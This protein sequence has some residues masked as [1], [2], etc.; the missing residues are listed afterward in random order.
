MK[1]SSHQTIPQWKAI[2]QTEWDDWRWQLRNACHS[3]G[4]VN[5]ALASFTDHR[6]NLDPKQEA[7]IANHLAVKITPQMVLALKRG[8]AGNVRNSWEAFR[9]AFL[10]AVEE[11]DFPVDET[12]GRDGIGEHLP[13]VNPVEA[14]TNFY[15]NRALFR[16]SVTCPGF[17]RFCF[18]RWMVGDKSGWDQAAVDQGLKYISENKSIR[19]VILSGG[20]P[21]ILA[22]SRLDKLLANIRRIEHVHRIRIDTKIPAMLPQRITAGL[23]AS[24]KK[25][26]PVYLILDF[27]HTFELST[28]TKEACARLADAGIPLAAHIPLLKG[29]NDDVD[30]LAELFET[31]VD[32]RVRPYYLIQFIPTRWTQ[33]FRVPLDHSLEIV[34]ALEMR[35]S[36][37]AMPKFIVYLPKAG[38]KVTVVPRYPK[39]HSKDGWVFENLKGQRIVYPE[40]A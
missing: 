26:N 37:L 31:L 12:N 8:I 17:C 21:L 18:R 13:E 28:E 7:A 27:C 9:G 1:Q 34:K 6:I 5:A 35:C 15:E 25:C 11:L 14:V 16:V 36:G 19:E 22:D 20:E 32:N 3:I 30:C 23:V 2:S 33:H 40:P 38:G 29:V 10:P 24:L 39:E 4:E